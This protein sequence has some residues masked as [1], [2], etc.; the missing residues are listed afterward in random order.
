MSFHNTSPCFLTFY[1]RDQS[2]FPFPWARN[3]TR[4][5]PVDP[6]VLIG[7]CEATLVV[8]FPWARNITHISPAYPAVMGTWQCCYLL[9]KGKTGPAW[10]PTSLV[11]VAI[12]GKS[13]NLFF[14]FKIF[15]LNTSKII[16]KHAQVYISVST[17]Q[18][19]MYST[20]LIKR[21]CIVTIHDLTCLLFYIHMYVHALMCKKTMYIHDAL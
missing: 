12:Q 4:I 14:K 17:I 19:L 2:L 16:I 3:F 7:E 15:V 6:A 11:D 13:N 5:A 9:G 21:L 1:C 18:S 10:K 8:V 20:A